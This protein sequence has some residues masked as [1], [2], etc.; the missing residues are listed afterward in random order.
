[1]TD[2]IIDVLD[3]SIYRITLNRPERGNGVSDAMVAHLTDLIGSVNP[4][5]RVIVIK[6]AGDDFCIGRATSGPPPA[7]EALQLRRAHD[8]VFRAYGALRDS[9]IPVVAVVRGRALGFGCALAAV[10]DITIAADTATFQIPEF[11]HGIMPTMVMSAL[12]DRA[13]LKAL[14]YQVYS[15]KIM[16]AER[17]RAIGIASEVVPASELDAAE[18]SFL[19]SLV[20]APRPA[21]LAVKEYALGASPIDISKA[22]DYARALHAVINTSSEMRSK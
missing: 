22:V 10:A 15:C 6:G 17:A 7:M 5:A 20:K 2:D 8:V 14:M 3:G 13:P 9:P 4:E 11:A 16:D 12:I 18:S 19:A 21:V 1:M